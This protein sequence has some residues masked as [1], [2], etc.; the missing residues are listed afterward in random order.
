MGGT[1]LQMVLLIFGLDPRFRKIHFRPGQ[2][3]VILVLQL[4]KRPGD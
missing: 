2:F 1:R 3:Q 4:I